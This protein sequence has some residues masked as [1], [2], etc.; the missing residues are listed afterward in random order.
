MQLFGFVEAGTVTL[1]TKP[2]TLESNQRTLSAAGFGLN[3][4]ASRNFVMHVTYAHRLGNEPARSAPD[5][6]DH[7]WLQ[8]IKYF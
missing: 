2:W 7:L 5:A 6:A 8:A 3:W 1:N 4:W